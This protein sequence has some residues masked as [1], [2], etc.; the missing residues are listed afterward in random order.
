M[1]SALADAST[2]LLAMDKGLYFWY[3]PC[4]PIPHITLADRL[5]RLQGHPSFVVPTSQLSSR[6]LTA[7]IPEGKPTAVVQ[8]QGENIN[9]T[10]SPDGK[11]IVVGN[12]AD[13][14]LWVDVETKTIIKEQKMTKEVSTIH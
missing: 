12:R 4:I 13:V 2:S 9:M 11:T 10:W 6:L 7:S 3:V 14:V 5:R 8:L 1:V